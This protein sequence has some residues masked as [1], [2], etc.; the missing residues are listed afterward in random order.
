MRNEIPQQFVQWNGTERYT[1]VDCRLL[2]LFEVRLHTADIVVGL[3]PEGDPEIRNGFVENVGCNET[4][5]AVTDTGESWTTHLAE[6]C[7]LLLL[8]I[9][10]I[11]SKSLEETR[12]KNRNM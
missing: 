8:P 10:F 3:K 1:D 12:S 11:A 5:L 6:V 7:F 9:I 4:L 2:S